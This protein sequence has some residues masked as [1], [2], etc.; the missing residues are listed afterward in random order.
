MGRALLDAWERRARSSL[1][2][3]DVREGAPAVH[4]YHRRGFRSRGRSVLW[5]IGRG[6]APY[7]RAARLETSTQ[8]VA[9]HRR[10]GF[11]SAVVRGAAQPLVVGCLGEHHLRIDAGCSSDALEAALAAVPQRRLLVQGT[12]DPPLRGAQRL[13]TVLRMERCVP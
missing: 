5:S 7:A 6:R 10:Y 4:W 3:L 1:L 12:D 2:S 9:R 13:H 11:S 8:D